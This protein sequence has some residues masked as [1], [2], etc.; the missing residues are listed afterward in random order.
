MRKTALKF[1]ICIYAHNICVDS[2]VWYVWLAYYSWYITNMYIIFVHP[3]YTVC[4]C[5]YIYIYMYVI[6]VYV[7]IHVLYIYTHT[8]VYLSIPNFGSYGKHV[9]PGI[10]LT[11]I[12]CLLTQFWVML[13]TMVTNGILPKY[14]YLLVNK[15]S[16]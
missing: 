15:H 14:G 2:N 8:C 3:T 16:Y 9:I 4:M 13:V 5:I 6:Y 10:P 1:C 7:Y 12:W 11:Y